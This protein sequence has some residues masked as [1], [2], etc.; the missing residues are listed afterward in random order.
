MLVVVC[1]VE[2][3]MMAQRGCVLQMTAGDIAQ[4]LGQLC[5]IG[6][7]DR[8]AARVAMKR[9][10]QENFRGKEAIVN[11]AAEILLMS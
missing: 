4:T 1:F 2:L 6:N 8:A 7:T 5:E 11:R 10:I 9:A 3:I